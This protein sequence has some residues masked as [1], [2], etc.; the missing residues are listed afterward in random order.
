MKVR[1]IFIYLIILF[2]TF[3]LFAQKK[4]E[5]LK[6][7]EELTRLKKEIQQLD[8]QLKESIKQEKINLNIL[9]SYDK[10][11]KLI[12]NVIKRLEDEEKEINTQIILREKEVK[13]AEKELES[14]KDEY[15][16]NIVN[17]YKYGRKN[18]LELLL[19]SGSFNQA[20]IRY[21]YLGKFTE[22]RKKQIETIN[23]KAR[24]VEIERNK[25]KEVLAEKEKIKNEKTQEEIQLKQ[26]ISEKR[27][28]VSQLRKNKQA[29][30]KDLE[31]KKQSANK[32]SELI[33]QLIEQQKLEEIKARQREL[34]RKKLLQQQ[35]KESR[36]EKKEDDRKIVRE[37]TSSNDEVNE[38]IP[39]YSFGSF[40]KLKGRLPWPVRGKIINK[41]GEQRN[42]TLNTITLNFGVDIQTPYNSNVRAIAEGK[43]SIISWLPGFGNII[44]LTHSEGYRTVYAYLSE[45]LI[46]EGDI[47][48]AGSVIAKS[49]ESLYGEMLHFEI[50]KEREK[51]NPE[52]WLAKN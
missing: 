10:Q 16:K 13:Q 49:G 40:T 24:Q 22:Y 11:Q 27:N 45:V 41:F 30:L 17:L 9:D 42:P 36:T 51:Q 20:L 23:Q 39:T 7:K 52:I 26:K 48:K 6:R 15:E 33:T 25:L 2:L 38:F 44:I 29:L 47:V 46:K 19:T 34:E 4:D 18:P 5:I 50:W 3:G 35:R 28:V 43:V 37:K 32:I 21:K 8:L 1:Y 14:L 12:Q 31:R